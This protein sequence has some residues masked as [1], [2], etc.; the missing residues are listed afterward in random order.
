MTDVTPHVLANAVMGKLYDVLTNG[1]D[2]V[3]KSADNF[4]SWMT[5]GIPMDP[6]DFDFLV[7]GLTGVVPAGSQNLTPDQMNQ[8]RAQNTTQV[9]MQAEQL[10]RLL[11]FVPEVTQVNNNQFAQFNVANN[12]GTLSDRYEMTLKMS[13]VMEQE[14]DAAT[15]AKIAKFRALLQTTTTQTDLITGAQTQVVGPSPLVQAYNAKML[16]YDAAALAYNAVRISALTGNDP[17][18]VQEWAINAPILRNQV[19]AAMDDWITNGY[20][21][22]YEEIAAYIDQVQQRDMKLLKQEYE[23]DLAKATLT[24]ISSGTNFWYTA[25]VPGNFASSSGWS[26]FTFNIGDVSSYAS[27]S[28]NASGWTAS[29]GGG[30]MGLF[31]VE[32]SASSSSTSN[33]FTDSVNVDTF[34]LSFQIAQVPIFYAGFKEAFL[35]SHTWRY[36]PANPDVKNAQI[37]DGASPPTGLIP[38]YPTSAIFI[39][40]LTLGIQQDSTAGQ[41]IDKYQSSAQSGGGYGS[42]GAFFLGGTASHYS[43][44]GYTQSTWN[45]S[46]N[47]QGLVVPGLQLVGVKCH[48]PAKSPAPDP[49][50]TSWV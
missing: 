16:A 28:F 38:A 29:A 19:T 2:T 50:I 41:F 12:E 46:W 3:P 33:E 5:P 18:A 27:S 20:K 43:N 10:A 13:Q 45:H 6:S 40:N 7:Q 1:D 42:F 44:S 34:T 47:D 11:D 24:G 8:L 35:A 15:Q 14:L 25:L 23:D 48:M 39:R 22:D 37:S 32:G 17:A 36:D 26:T 31:G 30:F 4:F 49:S 21:T 9:Y